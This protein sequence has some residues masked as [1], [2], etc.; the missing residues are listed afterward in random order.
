MVGSLVKILVKTRNFLE[1]GEK[2]EGEEGN[3]RMRGEEG[4][5]VGGV[6]AS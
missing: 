1:R 2:G 3:V 6:R 4:K 5:L